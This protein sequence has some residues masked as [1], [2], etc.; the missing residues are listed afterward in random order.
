M[1]PFHLE[2]IRK[3]FLEKPFDLESIR[4]RLL[5]KPCP[6]RPADSLRCSP[7]S[8]VRPILYS[9]LQSDDTKFLYF[10]SFCFFQM[11]DSGILVSHLFSYPNLQC[12]AGD[13]CPLFRGCPSPLSA[14]PT[15]PHTVGNHPRRAEPARPQSPTACN[16][17]CYSITC[18]QFLP[19]LKNSTE[20]ACLTSAAKTV[21]SQKPAHHTTPSSAKHKTVPCPRKSKRTVLP[22]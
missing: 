22:L 13:S 5:G 4:K 14:T 21:A 1:R 8:A 12:S 20:I 16:A 10:V 11:A 2:D 3:C 18:S 6:N 7:L 17:I 19:L 9:N 15:F